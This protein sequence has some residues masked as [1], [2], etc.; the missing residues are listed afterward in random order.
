M[1]RNMLIQRAIKIIIVIVLFS[2]GSVIGSCPDES[3]IG[4]GF[5]DDATNIEDCSYDGNANTN[6]YF[7]RLN[8][9]R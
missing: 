7:I 6:D 9:I 8:V 3:S 2:Q 1:F 5:C 4:D